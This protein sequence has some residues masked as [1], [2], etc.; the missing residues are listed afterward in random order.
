MESRQSTRGLSRRALSVELRKKGVADELIDEAV[1]A[2]DPDRERALARGLVDR[3]LA[4]TR[5]LDSTTRYRRLAAMLAR[6]GYPAGLS[7]AVVK[8]ALA[9][10][11]SA[12]P[13]DVAG[14][15]SQDAAADWTDPD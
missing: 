8:E 7:A 15:G 3:K 14:V 13:D 11:G 5:R 4:S 1:S 9:D 10:E 12:A 2:I 6:K